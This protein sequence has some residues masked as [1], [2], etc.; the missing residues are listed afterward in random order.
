MTLSQNLQNSRTDARLTQIQVADVLNV[1]RESISMWEKGARVPSLRQLED[2]ARL[3][4]VSVEFLLDKEKAKSLPSEREVLC[5]G[6]VSDPAAHLQLM[7]WFGFL[8]NWADLKEAANLPLGNPGKPPKKLDR[9][10]DFTD[11]RAVPT[12]A[13]EV[14]SHF[15]LGT[16][17]ITDLYSFLDEHGILVCRANLGD[18]SDQSHPGIS[19]VFH[20]HPKLGF[21][22]LV[23]S[24]N[25]LGRQSFTLAHEFAH[26]LFHYNTRSI[27]SINKDGSPREF[28]ADSFAN[29]FLVPSK[30][31]NKLIDTWQWKDKLDSLKAIE[32]AYVF[33]VSYAFMLIR[34]RNEKHI[35]E[36]LR[37]EWS[38]HSPSALAEQ[39]GLETDMFSKPNTPVLNLHR[40]PASVLQT[41]RDLIKNDE[42]SI[43]QA[44]DLLDVSQ[45]QLKSLMLSD[46]P[47][48]NENERKEV[49]EFSH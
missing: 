49:L 7:K 27:I 14:R 29:H 39:L 8:D 21:C 34:L 41:V 33:R 37:K 47:V 10:P 2:L 45:A 22:I 17:A 24:Q 43:S 42:L 23:N 46:I 13:A 4:S 28:F 48:A 15:G 6:L 20:N 3:Y 9:G 18:W 38:E 12:L 31:L 26:A 30:E 16:D 1:P 5:R 40:Y 44:A 35:S 19:G 36:E 25:S 11:G 32:L